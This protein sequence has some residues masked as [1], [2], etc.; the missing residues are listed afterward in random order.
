MRYQQITSE[1]RCTLATLRKQQPRLSLAAIARIMG[2]HP[3]TIARELKRN[4]CPYDNGYRHL[5]AHEISD[6]RRKRSRRNSHLSD[7]HWRLVEE[8]IQ[9]D[10]SP[11]QISGF[12]RR[13]GVLHVSHET[14]YKHIWRDKQHGGTLYRHL[15]QR[16]K[17]RKRYGPNEKRGKVAGKRHI[18]ERPAAVEHRRQVGHWEMDTVAGTGSKHCILTLVERATGCVLIGKL[19]DHTAAALNE[20]LVQIIDGSPHLFKTITADNGTEF[21]SY[22][23]IERL[24]GVTIYFATPYHAWERGTNEN[25]NGLIRQYLPKRTSMKCVTQERC[26]EIANILNNRPRKR[27]AFLT[28]IEK[29]H[30]H[31]DQL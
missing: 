20:R 18:S 22:E 13:H 15:R 11:E 21:H 4:C 12:L 30:H 10:F 9:A 16:P 25:T 31:I 23:H 6:L 8:L 28:P 5:R 17:Y 27:H 24:T 19:R 1:E 3:T 29:L 7:Q 2:R 26:N 14:I